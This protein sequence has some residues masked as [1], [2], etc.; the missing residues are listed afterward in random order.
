MGGKF[1]IKVI[2]AVN[3][4]QVWNDL[5]SSIVMVH[6]TTIALKGRGG[7][8]NPPNSLALK[9]GPELDQ[10]VIHFNISNKPLN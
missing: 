4:P 1:N 6:Q 3:K 10:N 5:L 7:R 8:R 9:L 2:Y